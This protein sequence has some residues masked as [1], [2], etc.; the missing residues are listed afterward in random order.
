L[1]AEERRRDAWLARRLRGVTG[2]RR[3]FDAFKRSVA[4]A[5]LA[6]RLAAPRAL[7]VRRASLAAALRSWR[8]AAAGRTRRTLLL[9]RAVA[10]A[11]LRRLRSSVRAWAEAAAAS[12]RA[13]RRLSLAR[14]AAQRRVLRAWRATA[15]R[16]RCEAATTAAARASEA[17]AEAEARAEA[18]TA[19]ADAAERARLAAQAA[20]VRAE[21]RAAPAPH[22]PLLDCVLALRAL[23]PSG[24]PPL[25]QPRP[26]AATTWV[27]EDGSAQYALL[28]SNGVT[29][30]T[31]LALLRLPLSAD[32]APEWQ[33]ARLTAPAS[34]ALNL[35]APAGCA[36]GVRGAAILFFGGF[37]PA[38]ASESAAAR[39]LRRRAGGAWQWAPVPAAADAPAA[40][41]RS[42][43]TLTQLPG[44]LLLLYGGHCST[45]GPGVLGDL[46]AARPAEEDGASEEVGDGGWATEAPRL[47]WFRPQRG[48]AAPPPRRDHA[49][50]AGADGRLYIHGGMGA[51]GLLGDLWAFDPG[52]GEWERLRPAGETPPP[53]RLHALAVSG[54]H[55]L[56]SGG[57][58]GVGDC[59]GVWALALEPGGAAWR[60]LQLPPPPAGGARTGGVAITLA[61]GS[62]LTLGGCAAG[63]PLRGLAPLILCSPAAEEGRAC[64]REAQA[65]AAAARA[66]LH[67]ARC[68]EA[69]EAAARAEAARVAVEAARAQE[70]MADRLRAG[71]AAEG[72]RSALRRR[73]RRAEAEVARSETAAARLH[74]A[75]E[76][77]LAASDAETRLAAMNA[78]E[79]RARL[80]ASEAEAAALRGHYA[81]TSTTDEN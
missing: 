8:E 44:G 43:A 48:G 21:L 19:R 13:L 56:L 37:D 50:A 3:G 54:A 66:A 4:R 57:H 39:L 78:T 52:L 20:L 15:T 75:L 35:E 23:S 6:E 42:H 61:C 68:A 24:P 33:E 18:G 40:P 71:E 79:L 51:E 12:R 34:P 9:Q 74:A 2:L 11:R 17:A 58:D 16:T 41:A 30:G 69:A 28:A 63:R 32:A 5:K 64:R 31:S 77:A 55:L 26:A 67:A 81:R 10:R 70:R 14:A 53:R 46:W 25:P 60:R 73:L 65:A 1:A 59:D 29:E 7:A 27:A 72:E 80:A 47:R 22:A 49:A 62:V 76:A 38:S 45:S 36:V